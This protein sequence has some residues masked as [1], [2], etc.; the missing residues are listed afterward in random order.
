M[1]L[2]DQ[3]VAS[4][5][6]QLVSSVVDDLSSPELSIR[7]MDSL[8][9]GITLIDIRHPD[10]L[11][12]APLPLQR[13]GRVEVIQVPFYQLQS[14]MEGKDHEQGYLLYCDKGMMSRLHAAHLADQGFSNVGVYLPG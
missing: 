11:E 12:R 14:F 10:E 2:I 6:I 13:D 1:Q 4:S 9:P 7:E 5:R 8:E 3:A